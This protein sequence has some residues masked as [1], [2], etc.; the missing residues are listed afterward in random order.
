[1]G[2]VFVEVPPSALAPHMLEGICFGRGDRTRT[3][4]SDAE[5]VRHHTQRESLENLGHR[6][7]DVEV[8]RDPAGPGAAHTCGRMYAVAQPL[9]APSGAGR[10]L[11]SKSQHATIALVREVDQLVP[12]DLRQAAPALGHLKGRALRWGC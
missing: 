1:M 11:V 6:L 4:L 2:Y 3:R 8:E 10:R 5:V 7:L 12:N 9:T